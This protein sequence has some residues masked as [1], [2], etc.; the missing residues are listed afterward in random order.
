ME[1]S[2][3]CTYV[4]PTSSSLTAHAPANLDVS[5]HLAC[6]S[7]KTSRPHCRQPGRRSNFHIP[8]MLD[9]GMAKLWEPVGDA[10][11]K[12]VEDGLNSTTVDSDDIAVH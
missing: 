3:S 8:D 1:T 4:V 9:L 6:D 11:D 12:T 7:L 10:E 5:I 2:H